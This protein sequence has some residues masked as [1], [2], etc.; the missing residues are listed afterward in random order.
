MLHGVWRD[1][2]HDESAGARCRLVPGVR[3]LRHHEASRRTGCP[4]DRHPAG[5][6][7][8]HGRATQG[9]KIPMSL[10]RRQLLLAA[11]VTPAATAAHSAAARA[12]SLSSVLPA[13]AAASLSLPAK[14]AFAPMPFTYLDSGSMHPMS[15]VAK[16]A[17]QEYLTYKTYDVSAPT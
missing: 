12:P 14:T 11:A 5:N 9:E 4:L 10:T 2:C 15:L 16:A 13:T 8:H 6:E 3:V 1:G 17:L 7:K